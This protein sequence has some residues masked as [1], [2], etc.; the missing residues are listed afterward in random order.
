MAWWTPAIEF[1]L[2][3]LII[4]RAA[5]WAEKEKFQN[6]TIGE[7]RAQQELA[8]RDAIV[9]EKSEKKGKSE[10]FFWITVNPKKDVEL[11]A[12]IKCQQKMIKKKWIENYAY[13]YET[14]TNNHIH[15]HTLIKA[16]YEAARARKELGNSVK[17]ICNVA[18]VACFKFVILNLEEAKQK[19]AYMLGKKKPGKMES[20]ELTKKWRKDN[21]LKEI[22]SSEVPLSCWDLGNSLVEITEPES[23][24]PETTLDLNI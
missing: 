23:E 17:D 11:P 8:F 21:M 2:D 22:Y 15:T 16:N 1:E 13:V 20:V 24:L 14:T 19:F 6:Q 18:N 3:N 9:S 12:L 7:A 10:K 5:E 4:T